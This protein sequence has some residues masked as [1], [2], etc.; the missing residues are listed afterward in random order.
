MSI[1]NP[2]GQPVREVQPDGR[3]AVRFQWSQPVREGTFSERGMQVFDPA[4]EQAS[5]TSSAFFKLDNASGSIEG[6]YSGL[7]DRSTG[8]S[9]LQGSVITAT[10]AYSDWMPAKVTYRTFLT[11]AGLLRAVL[12]ITAATA[13]GDWLIEDAGVSSSAMSNVRDVVPNADGTS[14]TFTARGKDGPGVYRTDQEDAVVAG[15]TFTDPRGLAISPVSGLIYIADPRAGEEGRG[16]VFVYD[17]LSDAT[18]ELP[19]TLASV[20]QSIAV[21]RKDAQDILYYTG[22][23]FSDG[24]PAVLRTTA[25]NPRPPVAVWKGDPLVSPDGLAIARNEDMYVADRSGAVYRISGHEIVRI[26]SKLT[27]GNPAGIA[28]TRDERL[29][30]VP[31]IQ[32]GRAGLLF[33]DTQTFATGF[34]T[35][36]LDGLDALGGIQRAPHNDLFGLVGFTGSVGA[37][38]HVPIHVQ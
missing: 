6:Y 9:V 27:L 38:Y 1:P 21:V 24:S 35:K 31:V 11:E 5:V 4:L 13:L 12:T 34:A 10:K 17:P 28:L 33:I 19:Q 8:E 20:P 29:V 23:D 37:V 22:R 25:D 3:V 15:G 16:R 2:G 36:G 14:F 30:V 32:N 18:E 26:A 7:V